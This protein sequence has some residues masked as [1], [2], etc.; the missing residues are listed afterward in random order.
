MVSAVV[1]WLLPCRRIRIELPGIPARV[2]QGDIRELALER[3]VVHVDA[4]AERGAHAAEHADGSLQCDV[5]DVVGKTTAVREAGPV[6]G[7]DA[8]AGRTGARRDVS[9]EPQH[10]T[11]PHTDRLIQPGDAG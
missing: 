10:F 11:G 8:E 1:A 9:V 5:D 6:A 2:W 3:H 7:E 4:V